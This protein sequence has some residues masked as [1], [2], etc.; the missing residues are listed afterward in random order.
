M[1]TASE[2]EDS[3][4]A[5]ARTSL[6]KLPEVMVAADED[7]GIDVPD[8]TGKTMRDVTEACLRLGL[9]PVLVGSSLASQQSPAAGSK[10]RRGSKIIV[11]FSGVAPKPVKPGK[12]H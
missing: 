3:N 11:E 1:Q 2:D 9:D 5:S 10:V 7:G 8:F 6:Q 12:H 4:A